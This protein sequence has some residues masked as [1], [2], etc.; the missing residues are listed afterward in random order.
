[1]FFLGVK[2][3]EASRAAAMFQ[4]FPLFVFI[5]AI[6]FL[7]ETVLLIQMIAIVSIV[8]GASMI[9][10]GKVSVRKFLK[11]SKALPL[12]VLGSFFVGTGF[13]VNKLALEVLTVS[14]VYIF[15]AMGMATTLLVFF[16]PSLRFEMAE[17]LKDTETRNLLIL[18][19][20]I[21]APLAVALMI[22]ATSRGPVSLVSAIVGTSP[23]FVFLFTVFFSKTKL[24]ILGEPLVKDV[25][26]VKGVSVGM[27]VGGIIILQ[28]T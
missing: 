21:L 14:A 15:R 10:L 28:I 20:F 23:M 26:L 16:R 24:R 12:L 17:N 27:I 8:A 4:T 6:A 22:N 9:S 2:I 5:F 18:N 11:P 1:M 13:F 19:P 7:G 25:L 3:E